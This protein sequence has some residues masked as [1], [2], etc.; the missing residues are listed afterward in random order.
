MA[1]V[2]KP[3][4]I[5]LCNAVPNSLQTMQASEG[6]YRSRVMFYDECPD[7]PVVIFEALLPLC[8]PVCCSFIDLSFL[9]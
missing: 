9:E 5:T 4:F 3:S 1:L 2:E 8:L 7:I 6:L